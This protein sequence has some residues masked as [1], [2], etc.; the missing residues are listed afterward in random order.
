MLRV[1]PLTGKA[2]RVGAFPGATQEG[3]C[4]LTADRRSMICALLERHSDAWLVE[5]FDP[6][7]RR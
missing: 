4:D 7:V 3:G 6:D 1:S 2:E 5:Q